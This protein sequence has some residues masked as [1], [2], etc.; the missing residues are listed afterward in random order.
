[1]HQENSLVTKKISPRTEGEIEKRKSR[2]Q[3]ELLRIDEGEEDNA[4]LTEN[5]DTGK[6]ADEDNV[7]KE[8]EKEK[9]HGDRVM[10]VQVV[11]GGNTQLDR[12]RN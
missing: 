10:G 6:E 4:E 9:K 7:I 5:E 12:V 11:G 8:M 1:M 2:A 3:W